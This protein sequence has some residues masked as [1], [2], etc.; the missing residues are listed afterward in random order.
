MIP[1]RISASE[2]ASHQLE[3]LGISPATVKIVII[4][5]FHADHVNALRDFPR[6]KFLFLKEAYDHFQ[7]VRGS[8]RGT[9][10]AFLAGNRFCP[11]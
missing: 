11:L 3:S 8:W 6:A 5:H 4:T 9:A 2:N 7:S 10:H 1:V